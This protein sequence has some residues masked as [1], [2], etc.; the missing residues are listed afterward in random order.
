MQACM[1]IDSGSMAIVSIDPDDIDQ[2]FGTAQP[3]STYPVTWA[4]MTQTNGR[5]TA[6]GWFNSPPFFGPDAHNEI[7]YT[8]T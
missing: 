6:V 4:V 7:G 2:Q 5:Y 1:V 8:T 3:P